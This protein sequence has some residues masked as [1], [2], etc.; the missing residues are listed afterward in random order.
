MSCCTTTRCLPK[1]DS[2]A[3]G[4]AAH[5]HTATPS[6][7]SSSTPCSVVQ[8]AARGSQCAS[9]PNSAV[10]K[11]RVVTQHVE[12]SWGCGAQP[13]PQCGVRVKLGAQQG[14][15]S[16][17]GVRSSAWGRAVP[18]QQLTVESSVRTRVPLSVFSAAK[19]G[20]KT[21]RCWP[22]TWRPQS[23]QDPPPAPLLPGVAQCHG[24]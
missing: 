17:S 19:L 24:V 13:C 8:D 7:P 3:G 11:H 5:R 22:L 12:L 14:C 18:A 20:K 15:L 6:A 10:V 23:R 21:N 1:L 2:L 4:A 9:T 16:L